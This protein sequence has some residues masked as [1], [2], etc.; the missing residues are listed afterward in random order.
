MVDLHHTIKKRSVEEDL[1]DFGLRHLALI[2]RRLQYW[3]PF[4]D[5]VCGLRGLKGREVCEEPIAIAVGEQCNRRFE[6]RS[7]VENLHFETEHEDIRG[8][9]RRYAPLA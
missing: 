3:H 2:L 6:T 8:L 9:G 1:L 7:L 5:F 4:L